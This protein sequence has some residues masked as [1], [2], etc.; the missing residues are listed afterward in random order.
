MG[1]VDACG[2]L[3]GTLGVFVL[4]VGAELEGFPDCES[5]VFLYFLLDDF[6][7]SFLLA[8]DVEHDAGDD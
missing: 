8:V 3:E 2:L 7:R 5:A 6:C 1:S 4:V